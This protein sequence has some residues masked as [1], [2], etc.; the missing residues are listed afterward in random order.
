MESVIG[1]WIEPVVIGMGIKPVNLFRHVDRGCD[2][3]IAR[4][5]MN[6]QSSLFDACRYIYV[7]LRVLVDLA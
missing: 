5:L 3:Y 7:P 1:L 4:C 6:D 2:E